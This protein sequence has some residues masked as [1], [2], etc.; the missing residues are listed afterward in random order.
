MATRML[1]AVLAG[2]SWLDPVYGDVVAYWSFNTGLAPDLGAGLAVLAAPFDV[3][4]NGWQTR[5]GSSGNTQA[6]FEA[7]DARAL[8]L[9]YSRD[10]PH[11]NSGATVEFTINTEQ[12]SLTILSFDLYRSNWPGWD[13]VQVYAV[14]DSGA[15]SLIA[16]LPPGLADNSW[17]TSTLD[18]Q[19]FSELNGRTEATIRF[20]FEGTEDASTAYANLRLDNVLIEGI[21]VPVPTSL[22][23]MTGAWLV[24]V[25]RIR[26]SKT[27]ETKSVPR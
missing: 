20:L 1:L 13:W 15:Q 17:R 2:L 22:A 25:S 23:V 21:P 4:G 10:Y 5:E 12:V 3:S 9:G 27:S 26:E 16:I 6:G 24:L 14:G 18:L 11:S 8:W 19:G 7:G